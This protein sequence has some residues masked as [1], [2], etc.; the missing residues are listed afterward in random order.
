MSGGGHPGEGSAVRRF[1]EVAPWPHFLSDSLHH[2]CSPTAGGLSWCPARPSCLHPAQSKDHTT[3]SFF[4]SFSLL[5]DVLAVSLCSG[6]CGVTREEEHRLP[7]CW[8]RALTF[9]ACSRGAWPHRRPQ[10]VPSRRWH[11]DSSLRLV[12]I[13]HSAG[14]C[15][16]SL[17][18]ARASPPVR[19]WA[20]PRASARWASSLFISFPRLTWGFTAGWRLRSPADPISRSGNGGQGAVGNSVDLLPRIYGALSYCSAFYSLDTSRNG[21]QR[22]VGGTCRFLG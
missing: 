10:Q 18:G 20:D 3:I 16:R 13:A 14:I 1:T 2:P 6:D 15:C 21:M 8:D 19:P 9:F 4:P 17:P 11:F 5:L 7:T 12:P 22:R